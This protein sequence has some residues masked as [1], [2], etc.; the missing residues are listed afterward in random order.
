MSMDD[1]DGRCDSFHCGS[2]DNVK[3]D[4]HGFYRCQECRDLIR[5]GEFDAGDL[6]N[7]EYGSA[8]GTRDDV[9]AKNVHPTDAFYAR[10]EGG[11]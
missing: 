6:S 2:T 9:D 10:L 5:S 3:V 7:D 8:S 4:D 1:N 11:E